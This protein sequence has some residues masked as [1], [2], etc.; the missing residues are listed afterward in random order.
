MFTGVLAGVLPAWALSSF[1]PVEVLKNL[2]NIKLFGGSGFRKTLIV[3]QF[4][5]SLIITIFTVTFFKQFNYT[6]NADPGFKRD[7]ILTIQ[8]QGADHQI[9]ANEIAHLNGVELASAASNNP[10]HSSSGRIQVKKQTGDQP[11]AMDY[12]DVD[13]NF[14]SNLNLSLLA[15][16]TFDETKS[17]GEESDVIL[18]ETSLSLLKLKS[19][20]EAVGQMIVLNDSTYV[21][22]TGVIKDFYFRGLDQRIAPMLL[23]NR[24]QEFSVLN[25][26]TTSTNN[27][28]L[29]Q[30]IEKIWKKSNPHQPFE[31]SWLKDE[32]YQKKS[33][34]G[35]ISML[36]FL[37]IIAITL[38]C[39]G[40][41]GMVVYNTETRKKEIGIRKVMGASVAE[42][43]TLL[44]KNFLK[45]V[46]I[47]GLIALP[48]SYVLCY[49][50]LNIFANRINLGFGLLAFSFIG[51][52]LLSLLTIGSQIYR[53]AISNPVNSIRAE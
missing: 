18:N 2:S 38:A 32:L 26:S 22:V 5:L 50:F 11:I 7:N 31:Y 48:V 51:M 47:S 12:F 25:V 29:I 15:G 39:L 34:W 14:I 20:A 44:S 13:K 46:M 42:I 6:A 21:R 53:V 10:G 33:A 43:I 17:S 35:T 23:R 1:K 24:P 49:M 40:L 27:K 8:L 28:A 16:K 9:L 30:S 41:L 19:P 52:L 3:L 37:A 4:T 36:G 45:L